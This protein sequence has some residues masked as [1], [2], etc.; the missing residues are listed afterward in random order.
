MVDVI[1]PDL[2]SDPCAIA[3]TGFFAGRTLKGTDFQTD[4]WLLQLNIM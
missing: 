4:P 3:R 1:D 2:L